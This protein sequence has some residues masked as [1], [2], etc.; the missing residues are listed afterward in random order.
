MCYLSTLLRLCCYS[1]GMVDSRVRGRGCGAR[2]WRVAAR[3]VRLLLLKCNTSTIATWKYQSDCEDFLNGGI[4]TS[5]ELV[6]GHVNWRK[7]YSACICSGF[8]PRD[9]WL[10]PARWVHS[11]SS[12]AT[13][14][15]LSDEA[16]VPKTR[17]SLCKMGD[18]CGQPLL[19]RSNNIQY[20]AQRG[21]KSS[22][23][24]FI[25]VGPL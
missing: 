4:L 6:M 15:L 11:S 10:I 12:F 3:N 13:S 22:R 14:I 7:G 23:N 16:W 21:R 25:S 8:S 24:Y 2:L 5:P 19:L 1:K 17:G 20:S 9:Q 18:G